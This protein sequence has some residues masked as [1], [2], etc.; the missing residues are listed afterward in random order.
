MS[1]EAGS[2]SIEEGAKRGTCGSD[3][4][5]SYRFDERL[6]IEM[7]RQRHAELVESRDLRSKLL[8]GR[9]R[10]LRTSARAIR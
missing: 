1:E 9:R 7:A 10:A 6:Q 5:F 2:V 3:A 8:S 4:G